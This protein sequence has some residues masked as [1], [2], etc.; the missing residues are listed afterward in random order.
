MLVLAAGIAAAADEPAVCSRPLTVWQWT[1]GSE[2]GD[3]WVARV[4][5]VHRRQARLQE[6]VI[7]FGVPRFSDDEARWFAFFPLP[8]VPVSALVGERMFVDDDWDELCATLRRSGL[9]SIASRALGLNRRGARIGR[10][11]LSTSWRTGKVGLELRRPVAGPPGDDKKA[12]IATPRG[13]DPGATYGAETKDELLG[14]LAAAVEFL[15]EELEFGA[16]DPW[17]GILVASTMRGALMKQDEGFWWLTRTDVESVAAHGDLAAALAVIGIRGP[18]NLGALVSL[19]NEPSPRAA[20]DLSA[21]L[22]QGLRDDSEAAV[23]LSLRALAKAAPGI[24]RRE[25]VDLLDGPHTRPSLGVFYL[26]EPSLRQEL[27]DLDLENEQAVAAE[28][29]RVLEYVAASDEGVVG[30]AALAALEREPGLGR[31]R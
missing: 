13:R 17:D 2:D 10:L 11:E 16:A 9:E 31:S 7:R 8:A 24:A 28:S 29:R 27:R 25:A 21:A 30:E 5:E 14:S 26:T 4:L 20:F 18:E 3:E 15:A 6:L 22:Q 12:S 19:G 23:A 1:G